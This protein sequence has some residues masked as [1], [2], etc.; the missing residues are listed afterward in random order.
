MGNT[1]LIAEDEKCCLRTLGQFFSRQG[2]TV[3]TADNCRDAMRI[4]AQNLPDC[5]LFD[6]N[7]GADGSIEPVCLFIRSHP[8]LKDAPILIL[9]GEDEQAERCY[10]ACQ[11]DNFIPKGRPLIEVVAA[12][13][14]TLRRAAAAAGVIPGGDITL[15]AISRLVLRPGRPAIELTPEQFRL[16]SLLVERSPRFVTEEEL[17]RRVPDSRTELLSSKAINMLAYRLRLKLGTQLARRIKNSRARGWIYLQPRSHK[18]RPRAAE[19][20]AMAE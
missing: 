8:R 13:R 1:I 10:S 4:A 15:D 20:A 18:K 14:R 6:Y 2:F 19:T 9:S 12:V 16:F 11:A 3:Y 17:C 5:F 7:M